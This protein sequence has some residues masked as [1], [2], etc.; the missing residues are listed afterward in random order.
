MYAR[1]WAIAVVDEWLSIQANNTWELVDKKPWMKVIPCKWVFVVKVDEKNIPTRFKARLVAGG[2]R[3]VEGIDYDET[4][5]PV[6]RMT[7]LR[8]LLG[9]AA[10]KSWIVHQLDIKTAF[11]HGKADL[12]IYMR[13]PSG[14]HDGHEQVCKL[15]KTLYGLKQAPRAWYFVLKGVLNE[16]DFHQVSADSSFWVHKS[17]SMVVFLTSIVDDML[18]V[19]PNEQHTLKLVTS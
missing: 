2:H 12:D 18:I 13:Q 15:Q 1:N 17:I 10:C 11:L 7:T 16:L 3:Q 5:A 8:I 19:S 4:Y 6:S 9:V 14:F